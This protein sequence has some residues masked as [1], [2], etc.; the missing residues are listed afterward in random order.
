MGSSDSKFDT[1][2][3]PNPNPDPIPEAEFYCADY[4]ISTKDSKL[5]IEKMKITD[6]KLEFEQIFSEDFDGE[7]LSVHLIKETLILIGKQST[8]SIDMSDSV[9]QSKKLMHNFRP[10]YQHF[11]CPYSY[12]GAIC[13]CYWNSDRNAIEFSHSPTFSTESKNCP[14]VK[15]TQH[16]DT[17]CLSIDDGSVWCIKA[18]EATFENLTTRMLPVASID[19]VSVISPVKLLLWSTQSKRAVV[20]TK[21]SN[22]NWTSSAKIDW[23]DP[24]EIIKATE[25][26]GLGNAYL[27]PAIKIL[28]DEFCEVY[29]TKY[30]FLLK[31][32]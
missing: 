28:R 9:E 29:E 10:S 31:A 4:K 22:G 20:L 23:E 3:T 21:P 2:D 25:E 8:Y 19:H 27:V 7:I 30:I 18:F 15:T 6:D 11:V 24:S 17:F 16:S 12:R 26:S 1:K 13:W 5:T 14:V 32:A